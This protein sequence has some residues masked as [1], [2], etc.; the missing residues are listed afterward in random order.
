MRIMALAAIALLAFAAPS[1]AHPVNGYEP[2]GFTLIKQ[3][4]GQPAK[5][6]IC[7]PALRYTL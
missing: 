3:T 2:S 6:P 5:H 1:A 4:I 7:L